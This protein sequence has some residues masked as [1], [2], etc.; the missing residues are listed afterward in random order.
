MRDKRFGRTSRGERLMA[1]PGREAELSARVH[2]DYAIT[3]VLSTTIDAQ[4]SHVQAVY[5]GMMIRPSGELVRTPRR[6]P[7][8]G[9]GIDA[10][11]GSGAEHAGVGVNNDSRIR[12][13]R[14]WGYDA[15]F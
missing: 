8:P 7:G 12:T 9:V 11:I 13:L 5:R 14:P 15:E 4:D 10:R 2:L 1:P 6:S 3:G